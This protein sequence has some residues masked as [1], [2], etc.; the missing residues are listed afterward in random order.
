MHNLPDEV[1]PPFSPTN[2]LEWANQ[3]E[4]LLVRSLGKMGRFYL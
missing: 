1:S 3:T 4:N 2:M